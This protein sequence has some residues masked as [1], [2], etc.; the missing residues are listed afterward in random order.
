MNIELTDGVIVGALG[1]VA[2][3]ARMSLRKQREMEER[4]KA[5]EFDMAHRHGFTPPPMTRPTT[6]R[7]KIFGII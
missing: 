1:V 3:L 2:N 4:V 5:I 6:K 7:K